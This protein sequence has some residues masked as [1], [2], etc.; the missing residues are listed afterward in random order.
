MSEL[1]SSQLAE[2]SEDSP[3]ARETSA[4][5]F[6]EVFAE[7]RQL[8]KGMAI[9][10]LFTV[11]FQ[12]ATG[13]AQAADEPKAEAFFNSGIEFDP[14]RPV[15]AGSQ[16]YIDVPANYNVSL[17]IRW[18]DPVVPGAPQ[19]DVNN[20]TAAKQA[21]QF[22]YNNDYVGYFPGSDWKSL[23]SSFGMLA[24]NHEY[25]NE[26]LMF[27]NYNVANVTKEMVD[28]EINAHGMSM[29]EV[30]RQPD[31]WIYNPNSPRNR[32]IT[33]FTPMDI[34]GPAAGDEWMRTSADPTGRRVLGTLN[35]C[36]GG[37]TPWGTVLTAEENFNQYFANRNSIPAGPIR[38]AHDRMG[39]NAGASGLRWENFYD[40]FD[41]AKEPNEAFRFGWIVEIDPYDP[42]SVPKKR[43]ALGRGKNEC[44][45]TILARD[46]RCVVYKGDDQIFEYVF[47][48]VTA[49]RVD[50]NNRAANMNL[51][52]E[53]TLYVARFDANG[54]GAWL[55]LTFGQGPLTAA[56]G[57]R[58]QA[59]VLIRAR[60]A[61]DALG[62]TKMDRPEDVEASPVTGKV[63]IACTNN[64]SRGTGTNPAPDAANPRASNRWGHIVEI[65]EAG[66]D[67]AA[68]TF[69]WD[70]F[71][72]CGDPSVAS[73]STFFAGF[74]PSRVSPLAA[75]DQLVI[76]TRGNLW[77]G[78]DGQQGPLSLNDGV[79]A[80]PTEGPER[81]FVRKFMACPDGAEAC[82][83]EFTPDDTTMFGAMQ[84][85]GDGGVFGGQMRGLW[86]DGR[87]TPR[88]SIIAITKAP[89]TGATWI[90]SR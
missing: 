28:I 34:T 63:Y 49:G 85:P 4:P 40:R 62:A 39:T 3:I 10:P 79:Y 14:I 87:D 1:F 36:A 17:V 73:Q 61:G 45:T 23:N 13:T 12:A 72:V 64:T 18:G 41:Q 78:T 24:V 76:D 43:T 74:D 53:G 67:N 20:Q 83:P 59:D 11:G 2:Q 15:R 57:W 50:M 21:V 31:A 84:H 82:G 25:V 33:G 80:C 47:K 48:F 69:R 54:T 29:I 77:I 37:K 56:N 19:F 42:N 44:A 71:M 68:L 51:L 27:R 22:G 75:P 90:G 9:A 70:M 52:D 88:P 65:T 16:D 89:R 7:R 86:P 32:R 38:S 81:G 26:E 6:E 66:G 46:G 8:L 35:N 55:P 58:N 5:S 30:Q 60:Q